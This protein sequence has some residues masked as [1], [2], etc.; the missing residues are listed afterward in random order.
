[1]Q[2]EFVER[3]R[4]LHEAR[5]A[6]RAMEDVSGLKTRHID[7]L[8]TMAQYLEPEAGELTL[9]MRVGELAVKSGLSVDQA[10][11]VLTD[12]QEAGYIV[13]RQAVRRPGVEAIT[14]LLPS[15]IELLNNKTGVM[16]EGEQ[17]PL[18]LRRWLCGQTA[19]VIERVV[20]AWHEGSGVDLGDGIRGG[21]GAQK[22]LTGLMEDRQLSLMD[23]GSAGEKGGVAQEAGE[24]LGASE[25]IQTKDGVVAFDAESF[26][27]GCPEQVPWEFLK[28]VLEEIRWRNA[29][30]LTAT[31]LPDLIAEAA[32]TR[33]Y[34][35]F[36]RELPWKRGVWRLGGV[37][38]REGWSRPR[39]IDERWYRAARNACGATQH[40]KEL[41]G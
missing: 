33:A 18:D 21:E 20:D 10:K 35:K 38:A 24:G 16:K 39:Q 2:W 1:M 7:M 31:S 30:K 36:C 40:H 8:V 17:L 14:T 26:K 12:L 29:D 22:L 9:V 37:M 11:R 25:W 34:G 28:D 15:A 19:E 27:A 5:K 4:A 32:Y 13:R 3:A 23:E 6:M 41:F